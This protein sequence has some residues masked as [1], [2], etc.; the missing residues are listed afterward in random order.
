MTEGAGLTDVY[1]TLTNH[2]SLLT[3]CIQKLYTLNISQ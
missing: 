3:V 2:A 1:I